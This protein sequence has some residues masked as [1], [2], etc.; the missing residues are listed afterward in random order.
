[1]ENLENE[2]SIFTVRM[3]SCSIQPIYVVSLFY[4]CSIQNSDDVIEG[5]IMEFGSGKALGTL[6]IPADL[7]YHIYA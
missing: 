6:Q 3:Q 2:K 7:I 4:I 1:M 5:K